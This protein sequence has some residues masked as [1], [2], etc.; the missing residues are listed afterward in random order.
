MFIDINRWLDYHRVTDGAK[1]YDFFSPLPDNLMVHTP[2]KNDRAYRTI[3]L[4]TFENTTTGFQETRTISFFTDRNVD[5][6]EQEEEALE[7]FG[8]ED[9][10][11][12][13][14]LIGFERQMMWKNTGTM[15]EKIKLVKP[16]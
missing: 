9:Y 2:F 7:N 8:K 16:L 14:V 6:T 12:D 11:K 5:G 4:G 10:E 13:L 15:W 1:E 3:G